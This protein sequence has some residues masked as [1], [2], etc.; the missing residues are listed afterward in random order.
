MRFT[1]YSILLITAVVAVLLAIDL[2]GF[3][4]T[5]MLVFL[6]GLIATCVTFR[7]FSMAQYRFA[8]TLEPILYPRSIWIL[9]WTCGQK[10][11]ALALHDFGVSV[12][13]TGEIDKASHVFGIVLELDS[14]Q[15]A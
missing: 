6:L 9:Q 15:S 3:A 4:L 12:F 2:H 7:G 14:D 10:C 8:K 11:T 5:A 13:N 1:I